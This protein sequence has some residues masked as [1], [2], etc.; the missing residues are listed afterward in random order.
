MLCQQ[1]S[2]LSKPHRLHQISGFRCNCV[3]I[4]PNAIQSNW[5]TTANSN[6]IPLPLHQ[7]KHEVMQ[8]ATCIKDPLTFC[9]IT[10]IQSI[11][12]CLPLFSWQRAWQQAVTSDSGPCPS[13][14]GRPFGLSW[15][16][17]W[18]RPF[19][20]TSSCDQNESCG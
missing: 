20:L 1:S 5:S 14:S 15:D 12:H 13:I 11:I 18:E 17:P 9:D 7:V 6:L 19:L 2:S 3:A 4:Q 16:R 8:A 10:I